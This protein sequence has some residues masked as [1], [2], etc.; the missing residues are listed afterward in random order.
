M[1]RDIEK[2]LLR[3]LAKA[4]A[5]YNRRDT[6]YADARDAL[7]SAASRYNKARDERDSI[8]RAIIALRGSKHPEIAD[9][10]AVVSEAVDFVKKEKPVA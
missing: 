3:E 7:D 9:W 8:A 10:S 6:D 4:Q 2:P 1:P 5:E